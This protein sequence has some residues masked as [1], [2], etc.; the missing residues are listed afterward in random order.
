MVHN[1][2][3]QLRRTA[4][5]PHGSRGAEASQPSTPKQFV[6]CSKCMCP[7]IHHREDHRRA[8]QFNVLLASTRPSTTSC[9]S[10]VAFFSPV[11]NFSSSLVTVQSVTKPR[12]CSRPRH[13]SACSKPAFKARTLFPSRASSLEPCT[14]RKPAMHTECLSLRPVPRA[15][16]T[17]QLCAQSVSASCARTLFQF[18]TGASFGSSSTAFSSSP[19]A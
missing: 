14:L 10:A 17:P 7:A 9:C 13:A 11:R 4:G 12:S 19:R 18:S 8:P 6:C 3:C 1:S 2:T 5:F 16:S 15:P